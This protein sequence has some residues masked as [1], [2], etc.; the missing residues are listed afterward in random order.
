MR[1][2]LGPEH[3]LPQAQRVRYVEGL[4][5]HLSKLV[6]GF[7]P[8]SL[9]E[10]MTLAQ[11]QGESG[12]VRPERPTQTLP[13]ANYH[14]DPMDVDAVQ[15]KGRSGERTKLS[16]QERNFLRKFRL[17][18]RCRAGKHMANKCPMASST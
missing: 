15:T 2:A 5:P 4:K 3:F 12:T 9:A 13:H 6:T 7:R 1:A 14:Y 16:A 17:R 11:T 8:T 18:F 10:A